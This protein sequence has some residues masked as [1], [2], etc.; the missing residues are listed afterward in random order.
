MVRPIALTA[1]DNSL[2]Y[3]A[4]PWVQL[5]RAVYAG[6]TK[7]AAKTCIEMSGRRQY[8]LEEP[9]AVW[10]ALWPDSDVM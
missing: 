8:V 2:V 3:V 6:E 10:M 9:V 1:P 7:D 4:A 5:I